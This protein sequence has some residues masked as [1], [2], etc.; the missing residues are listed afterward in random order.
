MK[1]F[2]Q[3]LFA[4]LIT[5]CASTNAGADEKEVGNWHHIGGC[6]YAGDVDTVAKLHQ[7]FSGLP[8]ADFKR[9]VAMKETGQCTSRLLTDGEV[10]DV[11]FTCGG[12]HEVK[13]KAFFPVDET[14]T[15]LAPND[16]RRR[17]DVC[18]IGG[19]I[20]IAYPQGCGNWSV[21]RI[22]ELPNIKKG[23]W[24]YS[25]QP[26]QHY[27]SPVQTDTITVT[28]SV[29]LD[30]CC[31]SGGNNMTYYGGAVSTFDGT[32]VNNS[33]MSPDCRWILIET[34]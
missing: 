29:A 4:A 1:K 26:G 10:W 33:G 22:T 27:S 6:P 30:N 31:C 7:K 34:Q 28:P 12:R 2:A 16:E 18:D 17:A 32:E 23:S 15:P 25:C 8:V 3:L 5:V 24:V 9:G 11:S 20:E 21:R 14:N 19:G 13:R